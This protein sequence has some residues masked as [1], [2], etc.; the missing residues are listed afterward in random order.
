MESIWKK[1][2]SNVLTTFM[3]EN[4]GYLKKGS[5]EALQDF[6]YLVLMP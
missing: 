1:T 5:T 6:E 3:V 2:I 4:S